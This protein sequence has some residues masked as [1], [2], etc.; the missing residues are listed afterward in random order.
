MLTLIIKKLRF[1]NNGSISNPITVGLYIKG[2]Y[3]S[4]SSYSLIED[5]VMVAVDG[6]VQESPLPSVS[7][8]P[9][10]KYVIKAVNELCDF[11]Y[12]QELFIYPYCQP[13]YTLADDQS[14]CFIM[15]ETDA[16]PPTS[17]ENTVAVTLNEYTTWGTLIYDEGFNING[18]GPFAQIPFTNAFWVNGSGYPNLIHDTVSGPLNRSGLWATT[19][20][21]GGQTIGFAVCIDAPE[22]GIYYVGIGVD[23][24][25]TIKVD[26]NIV[27]Q[28]DITAMYTYLAANGYPLASAL[29]GVPFRFWNVYPIFLN[30]GFR[31]LEIIATD[32]LSPAALGAE[33][34]EATSAEIQAATSYGDL[35][36]KLIFSTKNFIGMPVQIGSDGIG[37]TCPSGF[38]LKYCDSPISCVRVLRTPVLY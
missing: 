30:K 6:T 13:G 27:L 9:S 26:G 2:Y 28:M 5:G 21:S 31:V 11:V 19:T 29:T 33:V 17:P 38:S 16:T 15:E 14:S 3:Q 22:D 37:Y 32:L 1:P 34:Y 36:S 24:L 4:D 10:Q 12:T 35:G 20:L 8:D 7:I 23:D 18:T 25:A